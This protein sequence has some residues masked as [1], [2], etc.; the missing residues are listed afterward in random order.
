[1]SSAFTDVLAV[2]FI[3][4]FYGEFDRIARFGYDQIIDKRLNKDIYFVCYILMDL[5]IVFLAHYE[6]EEILYRTNNYLQTLKIFLLRIK[7]YLC[8]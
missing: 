3:E 5:F 1:M 4:P 8:F 2:E 6:K 7:L